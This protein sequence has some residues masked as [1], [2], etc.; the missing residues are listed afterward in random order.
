MRRTVVA[1]PLVLAATGAGIATASVAVTGRGGFEQAPDR[2]MP[3][4]A[5]PMRGAE[6]GDPSGGPAWATRTFVGRTGLLC[7][8]RGRSH[9]GVFGDVD[10][11][12][13]FEPRPS[14]PTGTCGDPATDPVIAV[15]DRIAQPPTTIVYGAS[16][17]RPRAVVVSP[18]GEPGLDLPVGGRGTFIARLDG[19]RDPR[20]LPLAVTLA[21]GEVVRITW[22][23][24]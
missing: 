19:L 9:G 18:A 20:T 5:E 4:P 17:R 10:G 24:A 11:E 12:G 21:D 15:V 1:I 3:G 23:G 7:V 14:G 6:A 16:L 22:D 2:L 8:E 13:R